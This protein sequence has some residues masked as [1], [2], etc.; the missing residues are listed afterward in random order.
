MRQLREMVAS[1]QLLAA[2]TRSYCR[3]HLSCA[4][5]KSASA[6]QQVSAEAVNWVCPQCDD[7]SQWY[8]QQWRPQGCHRPQPLAA[9]HLLSQHHLDCTRCSWPIRLSALN[10]WRRCENSLR[11][12]VW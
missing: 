12:A 5:F 7:H 9:P 1:T 6:L 2:M 3:C 4:G 11:S 10:Y 8:L